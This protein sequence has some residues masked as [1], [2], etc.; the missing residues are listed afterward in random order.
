M[1]VLYI[2]HSHPPQNALLDNLGGMQ[3]VS[4]QLVDELEDRED[5]RLYPI[6]LETSWKYHTLHTILFLLKLLVELPVKVYSLKPD[7]ILFSSMVSAS[8]CFFLRNLIPVPMVAINHGQDVTMPVSVYQRFLPFVFRRLDGVI[9][10]S[11]A[12][13][14]ASEKRGLK[15]GKGVALPNGYPVSSDMPTMTKEEARNYLRRKFNMELD[16]RKILVSVGRQVKRKGHYWFI[17]KVLPKINSE[18]VYI[19]VGDGPEHDKINELVNE[20][21]LDRKVWLLGKQPDQTVDNLYTAADLF[22]M[23]NIYVPGDMEGF[24]IVLLEANIHGTPFVASRLEGIRDVI[25]EG[26]NGYGVAAGDNKA[27]AGKINALLNGNL[28]ETMNRCRSYVI[29]NYD[30]K[31]VA[32][33]YVTFLEGIVRDF[34]H[35][36]I[37]NG[38]I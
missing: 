12:T 22:I 23:P 25:N 34:K 27:Y 35:K 33:R 16:N 24:G 2:S 13:L 6:V 3:R 38:R 28:K 26:V 19:L 17:D 10:V 21:H 9:S 5:V 15:R 36:A 4:M 1:K 31:I 32:G 8:L 30:W 7:V 20:R 29:N 11:K 37:S 18:I 14:E